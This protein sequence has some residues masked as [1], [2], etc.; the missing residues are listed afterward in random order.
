[1]KQ[2][3][4]IDALKDPPCPECGCM[5]W[6]QTVEPTEPGADKRTYECPRCLYVTEF[7]V[8]YSP[9]EPRMS[10]VG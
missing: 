1:M 5:M 4:T 9:A 8:R 6:L 10:E 2:S 7:E 3:N